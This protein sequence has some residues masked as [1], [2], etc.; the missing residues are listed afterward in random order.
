MKGHSKNPSIATPVKISFL[1]NYRVLFLILVAFITYS[2]TLKNGFV[3]DDATV[4]TENKYVQQGFTGIPVLLKTG[5]FYGFNGDNSGTYRPLTLTSFAI[6]KELLGSNPMHFHLVNLILFCL[7]IYLLFVFSEKFLFRLPVAIRFFIVLLFAVHPIHTEVV[8]NIKS[9]DEILCLIFALISAL[10]IQKY[11]SKKNPV[12]LIP[13][14]LSLLFALLS[15]ESAISFL[16]II[17]FLVFSVDPSSF[18]KMILPVSLSMIVTF[19]IY[20]GLKF[21]L[22]HSFT[23]SGTEI[24]FADNFLNSLPFTKRIA[25]AFTIYF[26]YLRLLIIPHPLSF[27]YSFQRIREHGFDEVLPWFVILLLASSVYYFFRVRRKPDSLLIGMSVFWG[28][29][30]VTSNLFFVIGSSMAERFMFIPSLGF[31]IFLF[32]AYQKII[33]IKEIDSILSVK[34]IPVI[35]VA[36][37][38]TFMSFNRN[39]DWKNNITL[40]KTDVKKVPN[41]VRANFAVGNEL[42]R[43]SQKADSALQKKYLQ[44]AIPYLEKSMSIYPNSADVLL[45]LGNVYHDLGEYDKELSLINNQEQKGMTNAILF[46]NSGNALI[47]KGDVKNAII[48][49]QKSLELDNKNAKVYVNLGSAYLEAGMPDSAVITLEKA[50]EYDPNITELYTNLGSAYFGMNKISKAI[51]SLEKAIALDKN[52]NEPYIILGNY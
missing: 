1:K 8:A 2:N 13:G 46:F 49:F 39:A 16:L 18:K 23:N 45:C 5:N 51:A 17:P 50:I 27:D 7:L 32:S 14:I 31:I 41:S 48:Q 15:K 9:R 24:N 42:W 12:F 34:T 3:L 20:S 35:A 29:S 26:Y 44:E 25:T 37:V 21:A 19:L 6:E 28:A 47:E 30:L 33:K 22:F 38:F 11:F 40:Y 52:A 36:L 43:M 4:I 10:S